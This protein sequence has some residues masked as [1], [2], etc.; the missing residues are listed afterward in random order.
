MTRLI[1]FALVAVAACSMHPPKQVAPEE[2]SAARDRAAA[3]AQ[4]TRAE[5]LERALSSLSAADKPRDCRR[6]CEL[7]DEI[8][9]LARR[10]CAISARHGQ[11]Q[12]LAD[13]CVASEQRC[14]RSQDQVVPDCSCSRR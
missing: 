3:V 12:D 8:C 9:E 5:E 10:I 4:E 14:R 2:S 7:V 1:A 13:R 6:G 11:D